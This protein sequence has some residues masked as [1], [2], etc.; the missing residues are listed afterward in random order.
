[1]AT[2]SRLTDDLNRHK[3]HETHWY[4]PAR[5]CQVFGVTGLA[6]LLVA[7]LVNLGE[8]PFGGDG[9]GVECRL[10]PVHPPFL[11]AAGRVERTNDE[12]E[13][14]HRCLFVWE[15]SLA[16][17]ALRNLAFNDSMALVEQITRRISC[18]SS[19]GTERTRI[20]RCPTAP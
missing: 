14:L 18:E 9:E 6:S 17:V 15:V 5:E 20:R 13:T 10:P 19:P 4:P 3:Q 11:P 7:G 1:M 8:S 2:P 16:R 12:V